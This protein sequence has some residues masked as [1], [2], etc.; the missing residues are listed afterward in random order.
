MKK[1]DIRLM[2]AA[3]ERVGEELLGRPVPPV[4]LRAESWSDI[5]ARSTTA[6]AADSESAD[7]G[8][9]PDAPANSCFAG[10]SGS[11]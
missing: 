8:S 2:Q 11:E 4:G 5:K 6:S 3:A 1:Q 9:N 10:C 7:S